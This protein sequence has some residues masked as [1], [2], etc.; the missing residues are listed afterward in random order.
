MTWT[1][2]NVL[3]KGDFRALQG[4]L[5][6]LSEKDLADMTLYKYRHPPPDYATV[7]SVDPTACT[8]PHCMSSESFVLTQPVSVLCCAQGMDHTLMWMLQDYF[9]EVNATDKSRS[10]RPTFLPNY[11]VPDWLK[12]GITDPNNIPGINHDWLK[13][14]PRNLF[15]C[16]NSLIV[17]PKYLHSYLVPDAKTGKQ[18]A[19]RTAWLQHVVRQDTRQHVTAHGA[20]RPTH[21]T[22]CTHPTLVCPCIQRSW[23]TTTPAR[24]STSHHSK[25]TLRGGCIGLA[26]FRPESTT[27]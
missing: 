22:H 16:G 3:T 2:Q 5:R 10:R 24:C 14:A 8:T 15:T 6:P 20:S 13:H 25:C 23:K 1:M 19:A 7:T 27:P 12:K 26:S 9:L 4:A 18:S 17:N 21:S 11:A